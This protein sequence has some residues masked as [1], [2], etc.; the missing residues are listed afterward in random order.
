MEG[1]GD[2]AVW[3]LLCALG[4]LVALLWT[5]D[6][7]RRDAQRRRAAIDRRHDVYVT[8]AQLY[9]LQCVAR[10]TKQRIPRRALSLIRGFAGGSTAGGGHSWSDCPICLEEECPVIVRTNCGHSLCAPCFARLWGAQRRAAM[11]WAADARRDG[12]RV[13]C[14]LCRASV[15][16]ALLPA[17]AF[18]DFLYADA[19]EEGGGA[20][21]S[22][23]RG[24]PPPGTDAS[25][26]GAERARVAAAVARTVAFNRAAAGRARS[27][28]EALSDLPHLLGLLLLS[29]GDGPGRHA[30]LAPPARR[31][32]LALPAIGGLLYLASPVDLL[33]EARRSEMCADEAPRAMIFVQGCGAHMHIYIYI[34]MYV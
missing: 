30:A 17:H 28:G 10:R 23:R 25:D 14:P 24:A 16:V 15:T 34:Y 4:T 9:T 3:V 27:L 19:T 7:H 11:R 33:P 21:G 32:W 1:L 8:P 29:R 2:D 12:T 6:K 5:I 31:L 20:A 22:R 13:R 18:A 26:A